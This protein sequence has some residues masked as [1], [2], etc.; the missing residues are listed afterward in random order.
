MNRGKANFMRCFQIVPSVMSLMVEFGK[1]L[2]PFCSQ[3]VG[4]EFKGVKFS[5]AYVLGFTPNIFF[6]SFRTVN[7][8]A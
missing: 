6:T 7:I 5:G 1:K 2:P 4:Y 3:I 8:T